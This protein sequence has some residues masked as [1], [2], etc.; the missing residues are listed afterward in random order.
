VKPG[1]WRNK[2]SGPAVPLSRI[3]T[4]ILHLFAAHRDPES[5]VAGASPLNRDALRISGDIDVFHDREERVAAAALND[6]QALTAAG[7]GVSWLRQLP[8]IYTAEVTQG[9]A[10][11][12]LE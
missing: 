3:Q 4:D 2:S 5:D 12:R 6:T 7:Y 11:T 10:S 8:L 1:G 9:D